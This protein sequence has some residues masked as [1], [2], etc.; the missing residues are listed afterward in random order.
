MTFSIVA[1]CK[2]TGMLGVAS[3]TARPAVGSLVLHA[4]SNVGAIATQAAVNPYFGIY[5]L[6]YLKEGLSPEEVVAK[7]R[8]E[9]EEDEKRQLI[10]VDHQGKVAGYMGEE[11]VDW[12]GHR[13]EDGLAVAGDMHVVADVVDQRADTYEVSEDS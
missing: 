4:E 2:E 5:G 3:S 8:S 9:D 11:T 12:T 6:Q 13:L 1:R 7:V 10:I